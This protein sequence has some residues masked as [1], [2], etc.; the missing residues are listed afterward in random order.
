MYMQQYIF[1][2]RTFQ[3][4]HDG[5][6]VLRRVLRVSFDDHCQSCNAQVLQVVR[7]TLNKLRRKQKNESSSKR[8]KS[9]EEYGGH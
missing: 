9:E 2:S 3:A 4:I 1:T 8:L 5:Q 7:S 6:L